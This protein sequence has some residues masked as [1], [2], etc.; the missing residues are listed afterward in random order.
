MKVIF[1]PE[2]EYG[3]FPIVGTNKLFGIFSFRK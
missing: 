3:I 1:A 2:V